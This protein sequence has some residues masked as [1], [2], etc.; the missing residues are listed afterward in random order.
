[1]SMGLFGLGL[2]ELAV[3]AGVGILFF[4]P[5]K[6]ADMGKDLGGIAG[7]VKKASAEFK[8]AM[9]VSLEQA[10]KE[11]EQRRI[12]KEN[13]ATPTSARST[14]TTA[15]TSNATSSEPDVS[16]SDAASQT[17]KE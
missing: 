14:T 16:P 9:E 1:M 2:G 8:E 10:D 4:G 5:S 17:T 11:I 12:E 13:Q 3:I 15:T 7:G 6:I